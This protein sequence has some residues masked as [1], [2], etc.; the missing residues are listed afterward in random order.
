MVCV[1][2]GAYISLYFHFTSRA[3][4]VSNKPFCAQRLGTLFSSLFPYPEFHTYIFKFRD[5]MGGYFV[6]ISIHLQEKKYPCVYMSVRNFS[7]ITSESQ[8]LWP[9]QTRW[10]LCV[11][12]SPGHLWSSEMQLSIFPFSMTKLGNLLS[13]NN[14]KRHIRWE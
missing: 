2:G 9:T 13:S 3:P 10:Y 1:D 14:L 4:I 12:S 7:V 6:H 5:P 11:I 8:A